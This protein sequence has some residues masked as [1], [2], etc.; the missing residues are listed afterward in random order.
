[1]SRKVRSAIAAFLAGLLA[2]G[3]VA[4]AN[5][6]GD[7]SGSSDMIKL[8]AKDVEDM[9]PYSVTLT[10]LLDGTDDNPND[11]G[12]TWYQL[13]DEVN[14]K[15]GGEN[16][17]QFIKKQEG[18]TAENV[19]FE[20]ATKVSAA[21]KDELRGFGFIYF[22]ADILNLERGASYFWRCGN[23]VGVY[24]E[25]GEINVP[26]K[27]EGGF[28]FT[29]VSD[30]QNDEGY[31]PKNY[32]HKALTLARRIDEPSFVV[33]SG[34]IVQG[35]GEDTL[36]RDMLSSKELLDL[37][38]MPISGNHDAWGGYGG[39]D[40]LNETYRHYNIKVP[41]QIPASGMYYSFDYQNCHFI[42]LNV[43]DIDVS[44]RWQQQMAWLKKDL[45]E[46]TAKWTIV[47]IHEPLY[48]LGKY[49]FSREDNPGYRV[50]RIREQLL[51]VI[52][53][54]VDLVLQGH[55]HMVQYT[56]PLK[57][58]VVQNSTPTE[59]EKPDGLGGTTICKQFALN[60]GTT[61][62]MSGAAGNQNRNFE[63]SS[64]ATSE[65]KKLFAYYIAADA[66]AEEPATISSFSNITVSEE[67][68]TVR[69]YGYSSFG[70]QAKLIT[71]TSI[72]K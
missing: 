17:V 21:R 57:G 7:S 26:D 34:D 52:E 19:T 38:V 1:M 33:H 23:G 24:G 9:T 15:N 60:G 65:F 56:Y 48:S 10:F 66:K 12:V 41:S 5:A 49:G 6:G 40:S 61:Y 70:L 67:E 22:Q 31:S 27:N 58:G 32:Y 45:A 53:G 18:Q 69:I 64:S 55:D 20:N 71:A 47:S 3:T 51:P 68:I 13:D 35:A 50:E 39:A 43:E 62:L 30:T 37:P 29:H 4:C 25:V 36:W 14:Q 46:N 8:S 54:K 72:R 16:F 28:T 59:V 2:F 63:V 44:N 42:M 11:Y